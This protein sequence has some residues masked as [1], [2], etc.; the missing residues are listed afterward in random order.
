MALQYKG[1]LG[2][3]TY[4]EEAQLLHGEVIGTRSVITFQA[5]RA[6]E[7]EQAFRDSI[8]DYLAWCKEKGLKPDKPKSGRFVVRLDPEVHS[9]VAAAAKAR[10]I[11]L[12]KFVEEAL[13]RAVD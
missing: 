2:S 4:D 12:N 9:R 10:R 7:V 3:V 5:K 13:S 1:F 8:D 6:D 11:S